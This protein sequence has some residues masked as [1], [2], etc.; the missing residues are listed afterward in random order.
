M[1]GKRKDIEESLTSGI[2]V[3]DGAMGSLLKAYALNEERYRGRLCKHSSVSLQNCHELLNLTQAHIIEQI[4]ADYLEAGA[5]II[6]TN[7]C[8]A[9]AVSLETF[10]LQEKAYDI[11]FAAAQLAKKTVS[12]FCMQR[13]NKSKKPLIAGAIGPTNRVSSPFLL[14]Q[15]PEQIYIAPDRLRQAYYIQAK[16]LME[17]GVDLFLIETIFDTLNAKIALSALEILFAEKRKNL[18]IMCSL[19]INDEVKCFSGE[20]ILNFIQYLSTLVKLPLLSFGL[21]CCFGSKQMLSCLEEI[22]LHSPF[23]LSAYPNA[24]LPD[25]YG[26][27]PQTIN[28]MAEDVEE[29]LKKEIV[30]IIGGCCGT[31]PAHIAAIAEV[32]KKHKAKPPLSTNNTNFNM[33]PNFVPRM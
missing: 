9:N 21:N 28:N 23:Y 26:T 19:T 5:D 2:L 17:G 12:N 15:Y 24:G 4:H 11:N 27:Y 13:Q 3:L 29:I 7:T 31:T 1:N 10:A 16:A 30:H 33:T 18:P 25:A 8:N 20:S 6:T 22:A 14:A 32:A